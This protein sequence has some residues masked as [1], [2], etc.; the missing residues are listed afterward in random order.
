MWTCG[1]T[2]SSQHCSHDYTCYYKEV[3][4]CAITLPAGHSSTRTRP[5][6]LSSPQSRFADQTPGTLCRLSYYNPVIC[7]SE[8][9]YLF[10]L[11]GPEPRTAMYRQLH[12]AVYDGGR[13]PP[14]PS[15]VP[16]HHTV[17]Q[18]VVQSWSLSGRQV[19]LWRAWLTVR[20]LALQPTGNSLV[21]R[22]FCRLAVRHDCCLACC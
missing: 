22:I 14:L 8:L 10:C 3:A 2:A 17:H 7:L 21:R 18:E 5:R 20:P 19:A 11:Q 6:A 4:P 13:A 1:L 16:Q 9:S 12:T 15:P